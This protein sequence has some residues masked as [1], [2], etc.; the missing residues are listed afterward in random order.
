MEMKCSLT[1]GC[2]LL[3][4]LAA[5]SVMA[6]PVEIGTVR[7]GTDLDAALA[8]SRRS[9][10]PVFLLFQEVPG[11]A[12]CRDFGRT[13]LS[14][15]RMVR[16]IESHFVPV[17]I[18]NNRPGREAEIL[19]KFGEPAWNYQVVRFLDAEGRDLIPR[20]DRVWDT[21]T[22][23]ARMVRSLEAA[24]RPV[25]EGL[26]ALAGHGSAMPVQSP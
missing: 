9:G 19:R 8:E 5:A 25:D 17:F 14:E 16:A 15:D 1:L 26:G 7:W 21:E 20:K 2:G 3:M 4:V 18:A 12:G 23:A 22:L 10:R 24:G 6:R 13:V 11:C